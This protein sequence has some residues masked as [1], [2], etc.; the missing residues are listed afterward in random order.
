M[1]EGPYFRYA[2]NVYHRT[3]IKI[4]FKVPAT[5]KNMQ[6]LGQITLSLNLTEAI[7]IPGPK[8]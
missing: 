2:F 8:W 4:C 7:G 3:P 1:E 5:R 6:V